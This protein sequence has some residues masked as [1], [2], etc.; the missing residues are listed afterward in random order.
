MA[1]TQED[2]DQLRNEQPAESFNGLN[3][4]LAEIKHKQGR[5]PDVLDFFEDGRVGFTYVCRKI[6]DDE[7]Y[8]FPFLNVQSILVHFIF[9]PVAFG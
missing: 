9:P 4:V 1:V 7:F 6:T 2:S 8:E 5:E 3:V